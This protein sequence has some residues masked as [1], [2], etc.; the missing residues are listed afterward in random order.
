MQKMEKHQIVF[1]QIEDNYSYFLILI[2]LPLSVLFFFAAN[3]TIPMLIYL[4]FLLFLSFFL[5]FLL[6][7]NI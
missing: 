5:L 7:L 6:I 2:L 1:K 4:G 3:I